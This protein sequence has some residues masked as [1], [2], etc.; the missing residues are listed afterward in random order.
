MLTGIRIVFT[1]L[2]PVKFVLMSDDFFEPFRARRLGTESFLPNAKKICGY[3]RND[4]SR[5]TAQ[6]EQKRRPSAEAYKKKRGAVASLFIVGQSVRWRLPAVYCCLLT[7]VKVCPLYWPVRAS[8]KLLTL[9]TSSFDIS[10]P[11]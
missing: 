7:L 3:L 11:T 5:T 4:L 6:N 2:S 10:R 1:R 8:R 9:A